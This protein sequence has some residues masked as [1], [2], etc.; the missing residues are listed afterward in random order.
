MAVFTA[1]GASLATGLGFATG[2]LGFTFVSGLTAGALQIAA[3][4][5]LS[6]IGKAL[7][8]EP[9]KTKFGIQS[10]IQGGDNV[11]RSILFGYNCTAGSI[12][13]VNTWG[14][15]NNLKNAYLTRVI[16][17][18]D[19][20]IAGLQG[21]II[22][23]KPATLLTGS[24]HADFGYPVEEYRKNSRDHMWVKFY[25][26][27]QISADPFLT[28][29]V[30]SASRPWGTNRI[31]D[32]VAYAIVTCLAPERDDGEEKPLF[33]GTPT[34]K[35]ITYGAKLYDISLDSTAGGS[36]THRYNDKSTWG[37]PGDFLPSVQIYNVLRGIFYNDLWLYGLQTTTAYQ[38]PSQAWID[39][40]NKNKEEV[41]GVDGSEPLYRSGGEIQVGAQIKDTIE[42][43]LTACQ[44]RLSEIGGVYKLNLGEPEPYVLEITDNE[45]LTSEEQSFTPFYG[46]EDTITGIQA[47]YPNPG[48]GWNMKT[49]PPLVDPVLDQLAGNRRLMATITLDVVPYGAQTQR[50][51]RAA[52][53]EA[54][55][56]RRHTFTLGPEYWVL[57]PG[58][59]IRWTSIRN[60]YV[61][62]LF[63][64]DGVSDQPDLNIIVDI[65]EVDPSDYDWDQETDYTP[66]INGPLELSVVPPLA[67][68]GWQV[69]PAAI[70]DDIGRERRPSI[71]IV[72]E[73]GIVGVDKVRVQV[74]IPG[75]DL[76]FIDTEF[77]YGSPYRIQI[78]GNFPPNTVYEVRGIFVLTGG[79]QAEWSDWLQV[80]TPDV[81]FIAGEDFDPYS[82]V[83]DFDTIGP[84]LSAW[85]EWMGQS[86]RELMEAIQDTATYAADQEHANSIQFQEVRYELGQSFGPLQ[87][88]FQQVITVAII[89]LQDEVA[90]LADWVTQLSAGDG[91][92]VSTARFRMTA[93]SGPTGYARIGAETR[94]DAEDVWRGASWYLDTPNDPELPTRF[95]VLADQFIITDGTDV[96]APFIFEAGEAKMTAARIGTI[97]AGRI[98]STSGTSFWDLGTGA[99]RIATA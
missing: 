10:Q 47:S 37:G 43:F 17:L 24:P 42:A 30:A 16:A 9:S 81:K 31:G 14:R 34:I 86:P 72:Y 41:E 67:M 99:F 4:I 73:S 92:D 18:S 78:P 46:L 40:I 57:E 97:K 19:Y 98:Q 84:G 68:V 58:D 66:V 77:P 20:P 33:S 49:A 45:I 93:L 56:A 28:G 65:T 91:E 82:G 22:D 74:R 64:I 51:M 21:V 35:F 63:R 11:P 87:A 61:D 94:V 89:P 95:L 3:G 54:Q 62:K 48:E 59:V 69:Y 85:I 27:T 83:V 39:V 96:E 53:N 80:T 6:L 50:L 13:Y 75:E 90:A 36:G 1:I 7:A 23:E 8:G 25:D 29:T 2:T 5:G 26:G 15:V 38:L 88:S 76:P 52:L 79:G 70:Y 44:G 32:G 12:V 71:E 60:G 55:R